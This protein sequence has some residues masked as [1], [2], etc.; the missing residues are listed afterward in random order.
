MGWFWGRDKDHNQSNDPVNKLDPS[1]RTF[2]DE[3]SKSKSPVS[4]SEPLKQQTTPQ[5]PKKEESKLGESSTKPPLDVPT[6]FP[7]GRYAHLWKT[8]GSPNAI[9]SAKDASEVTTDIINDYKDR[10]SAIKDA[11]RINCAD[12]QWALDQCYRKPG[13]M[14]RVTMCRK[15]TREYNRCIDLNMVSFFQLFTEL[16]L[17]ILEI[18]QGF[19]LS[20]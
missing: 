1:L 6:L 13:L 7:D 9:E 10:R 17:T 15:E 12:Q 2:L 20:N 16:I 14:G 8:Y 11:A 5:Q 19:G 3:Q 4:T 18:S